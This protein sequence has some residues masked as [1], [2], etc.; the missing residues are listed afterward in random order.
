MRRCG[1]GKARDALAAVGG[2]LKLTRL[3][4]PP[5]RPD[6]VAAAGRFMMGKRLQLRGREKLRE[7]L[8]RDRD[9][10]RHRRRLTTENSGVQAE[11]LSR[12]CFDQSS[13]HLFRA[14]AIVKA[15]ADGQT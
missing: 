7:L 12:S 9:G 6:T 13:S 5:A 14:M 10:Q 8:Q 11:E 3:P 15:E 2:G 4:D 1:E